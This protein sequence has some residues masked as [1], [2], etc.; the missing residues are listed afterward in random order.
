LQENKQLSRNEKLLR[1]RWDEAPDLGVSYPGCEFFGL[2]FSK[3]FDLTKSTF[4][5][6]KQGPRYLT[7]GARGSC[8]I[9]GKSLAASVRQVAGL[10][11][12]QGPRGLDSCL[13]FRCSPRREARRGGRRGKF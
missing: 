9:M 8:G 1:V 12:F 4:S 7:C 10:E 5:P 2:L 11:I 13:P 6:A 3:C